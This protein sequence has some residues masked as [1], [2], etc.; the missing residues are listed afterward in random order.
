VNGDPNQAA[1]AFGQLQAFNPT[2]FSLPA[3][4]TPGDPSK[5]LIRGPGLNDWDISIFKDFR[6]RERLR[7]QLRSELYNALNHVHFSAVNAT[8]QFNATG[9]G[10]IITISTANC[11]PRRIRGIIIAPEPRWCRKT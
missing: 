1:G 5:F 9:S 8:A 6:I 10:G 11:A 7:M 2:V 4:G 3:V